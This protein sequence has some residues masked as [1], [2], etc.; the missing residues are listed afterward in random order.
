MFGFLCFLVYENIRKTEFKIK[1]N[2]NV[3]YKFYSS[4]K[5]D[6]SEIETLLYSEKK[7]VNK[8]FYS[9]YPSDDISSNISDLSDDDEEAKILKDYEIIHAGRC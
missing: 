4:E 8:N 2:R 6:S 3:K 5:Y 7:D 9:A 1:S